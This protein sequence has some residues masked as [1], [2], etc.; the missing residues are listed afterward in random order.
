M[1]SVFEYWTQNRSA[2][3]FA[4][5]PASRSQAWYPCVRYTCCA[6]KI[7]RRSLGRRFFGPGSHLITDHVSI[8][9]SHGW[10]RRQ[11]IPSPARS[12]FESQS[13]RR[14]RL[15]VDGLSSSWSLSRVWL[16]FGVKY[17]SSSPFRRS[18]ALL[19]DCSQHKDPGR[20]V[21]RHPSRFTY[22]L[23]THPSYDYPRS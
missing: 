21:R 16:T 8:S 14:A 5:H 20:Q 9:G 4:T 6:G 22:R 19:F 13:H 23:Y 15:C 17:L 2:W 12:A 18:W 11:Y 10:S 3:H 1:C 7:E